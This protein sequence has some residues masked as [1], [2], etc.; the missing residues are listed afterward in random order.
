MFPGRAFPV[1]LGTGFGAGSGY[2]DCERTFNPVAVPG[3]RI[4]SSKSPE[5]AKTQPSTFERL[6]QKAGEAFGSAR[7]EAGKQIDKAQ[8]KV[9]PELEKAKDYVKDSAQDLLNK[10][11]SGANKVEDKVRQV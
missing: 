11:K 8:A 5:A 10:A 1:W 3:V 7:Q 2:T 6:Q 4:V 9:E